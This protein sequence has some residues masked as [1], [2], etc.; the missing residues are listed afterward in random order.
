[1]RVPERRKNSRVP[2]VVAVKQVRG[3]D[4]ALFQSCDLSLVGMALVLPRGHELPE[5]TPTR[6][7][8]ALPGS[9]KTIVVEAIPVQK[10][11]HGRFRLTGVAFK[12]IVGRKRLEAFIQARAA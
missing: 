11:T 7:E 4:L 12:K 2:F 5:S 6:L 3:R 1:M 8:F 10:R 9:E